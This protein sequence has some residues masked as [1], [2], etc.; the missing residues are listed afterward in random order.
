MEHR[1]HER[2]PVSLTTDVFRVRGRIGCFKVRDISRDGLFLETGPSNLN[3]NDLLAL[4]LK[5]GGP[6]H[7]LYGVVTRVSEEGAGLALEDSD[8][9]EFYDTLIDLMMHG[10]SPATH[11]SR[12]H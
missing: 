7:M 4:L 2:L 5:G 8:E 3:R 6:K 9:R 1:Y 12:V 11:S 10:R